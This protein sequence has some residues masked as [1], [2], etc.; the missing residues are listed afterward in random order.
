M[1]DLKWT[2]LILHS[3]PFLQRYFSLDQKNPTDCLNYNSFDD[4]ISC[5]DTF[6]VTKAYYTPETYAKAQPTNA[7]LDAWKEI[8]H[9]LLDVGRD[10]DCTSIVVPEV[11]ADSYTV[12]PFD[13]YCV[14]HEIQ[15]NEDGVYAKGWGLMVVP[16]NLSSTALPSVHISSP[17]PLFDYTSQQSAAVFAGTGAKSLLIS[18]RIRSALFNQ[19]DCIHPS[20][21][22][23]IYYKTDPAH[24]VNEPFVVALKEIYHWQHAQAGGCPPETCAFIQMHGKATTTCP[25]DQVF[26]SSGLSRSASSVEWYTSPSH[27]HLPIRRLQR[28]L[29]TAFPTWN[30]SLPSDSE[31]SL[32]ATTNVFGRYVNGIAEGEVCVKGAT[33]KSAT[34]EFV[35]VEQAPVAT[36]EESYE[37]WVEAVRE[38]FGGY[39]VM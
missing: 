8:T 22:T 16:S 12:S 26:L 24:D 28:N 31:C 35:H 25:R 21:N 6:T 29:R 27:E 2:A 23:T 9:L 1:L 13:H 18:G 20:S 33:A 7:E 19:T 36:S 4:L 14:L 32:T 30:I 5:F 17:H 11:L 38:A 39:A 15:A 37:A 34:G 3:I 10:G